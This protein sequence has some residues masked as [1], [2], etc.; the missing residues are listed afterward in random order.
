MQDFHQ[1]RKKFHTCI[2]K[3]NIPIPFKMVSKYVFLFPE[4]T[5]N[6]WEEG[7]VMELKSVEKKLALFKMS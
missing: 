6:F 2:Q 5:D 7:W 1:A 3:S 4:V